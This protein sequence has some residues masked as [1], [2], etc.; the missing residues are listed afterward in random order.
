MKV[1]E[2]IKRYSKDK[3][4]GENVSRLSVLLFNKLKNI[5]PYLQNYDTESSVN[6][7]KTGAKLHDI[8]IYFEKIYDREHN[9]AGAKFILNNKPDDIDEDEL[10]IL[11]CIIRYHRKS[12]PDSSKHKLYSLLNAEEKTRL[13]YFASIVRLA[14]GLDFGHFNLVE[15][16]DLEY[17]KNLNVLTLIA[18]KNIMLNVSIVNAVQRKKDFLEKVFGV[19]LKIKGSQVC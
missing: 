1:E 3:D 2:I 6:L 15:D 9:K 11:C 12:L 8:G 18:E 16:F 10:I 17:D 7:L 5:F 19:S 4:H 13:N 14:D